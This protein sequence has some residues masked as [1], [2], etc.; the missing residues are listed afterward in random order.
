MPAVRL[1]LENRNVATIA[2]AAGRQRR[3]LP[4]PAAGAEHQQASL[5]VRAGLTRRANE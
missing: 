2:T 1:R 5:P 4:R 3:F